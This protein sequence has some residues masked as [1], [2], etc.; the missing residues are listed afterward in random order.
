MKYTETGEINFR[1]NGKRTADDKFMLSLA[2]KDTGIGIKKEIMDSLFTRFSRADD[3]QKKHIEGT[4][5]GLAIVKQ[6][7]DLMGGEIKVESEYGEGSLFEVN[8]P[9]EI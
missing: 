7:V 3:V 8:V 4:G 1:V 5:L 2:V 9:Q 6:L